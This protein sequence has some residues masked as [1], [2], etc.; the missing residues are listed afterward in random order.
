MRC[1]VCADLG[2]TKDN[3]DK[4]P[5]C[6]KT[7]VNLST[8]GNSKM[9]TPNIDY[10][11]FIPPEYLNIEYSTQ[12]LKQSH[13]E[14]INDDNFK[15]YANVLQMLIDSSKQG[16]FVDN[17][18]LLYAPH[19]YAKLT[20]AYNYIRNAL[21]YVSVLPLLDTLD[22]ERMTSFDW[23]A[24]RDKTYYKGIK[25][26][27]LYTSRVCIIKIPV[28]LGYKDA[29]RTILYLIDKRGRQGLSTIFLSR[30]SL[31]T[32]A[33]NDRDNE[34]L[35]LFTRTKSPLRSKQLLYIPYKSFK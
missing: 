8:I 14:L 6:G 11:R 3:P 21:K 25:E 9:P 32:L 35:S 20:F 12:L 19:G 18:I 26:T 27:D 23:Y 4:C 28:G 15:R 16:K 5:V 24:H 7:R 1:R 13:P 30:Y 33:V 29:F 22:I 34:L 10:D 31:K 2:F 17:N